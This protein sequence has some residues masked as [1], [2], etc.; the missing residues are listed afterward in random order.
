M[1]A[2]LHRQAIAD[3]VRYYEADAAGREGYDDSLG[4]LR[5]A[6]GHPLELD[7]FSEAGDAELG[8]Q[9]DRPQGKG[10][11]KTNGEGAPAGA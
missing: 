3:A 11:S 6:I 4:V 9:A 8:Q 5:K 7:L 1:D 2:G 10:K